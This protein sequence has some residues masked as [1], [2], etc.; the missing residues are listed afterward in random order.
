MIRSDDGEMFIVKDQTVLS[1]MYIPKYFNHCKFSSFDR[2]LNLYGFRKNFSHVLRQQSVSDTETDKCKESVNYVRFHHRHFKRGRT[3]LLHLIKRENI[4]KSSSEKKKSAKRK[5]VDEVQELKEE[6][7]SLE[8]HLTSVVSDIEQK[9]AQLS[10]DIEG[11]FVEMQRI[12][13]DTSNRL[14]Q[15][16][17]NFEIEKYLHSFVDVDLDGQTLS[18]EL[19]PLNLNFQRATSELPDEMNSEIVSLF[20]EIQ[21]TLWQA[22]L[23]TVDQEAN[24]PDSCL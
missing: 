18:E 17:E 15:T 21:P 8:S 19:Q 1:K 10:K 14:L 4:K 12:V 3:D 6:L 9:F 7:S 16:Q 24:T 2:Q 23:D 22:G 11:K 13:S 20:H 5:I